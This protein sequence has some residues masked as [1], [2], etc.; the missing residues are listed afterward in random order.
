[1]RLAER[2]QWLG[3][4]TAFAV[5]AEAHELKA[6]GRTVY[7]FHLGDM[8]L[9]TPGTVVQGA[10][11]ALHRGKTGYCP[12]A[13]IP[14]LREAL[15]R[16]MNQSRG[17]RFS[18]ANVAVQPGGK[19]VISKFLLST[20]NP[21]D[22]VLYPNPG[23]PIYESQ[24]EFLGGKAVPYGFLS[25]DQGFQLD[26]EGMR[27]AVSP[28]TRLLVLNDMHN[29]TGAECSDQDLQAVAD[30]AIEHDLLVL[31]DEAYFDIRFEGQSR[32]LAS[33]PGMEERCLILYTFSK[34]FAMTGWRLGAAIGPEELIK[35][36]TRLNVNQESCSSHFLQFGA[37]AGLQGDQSEVRAI[38]DTLRQRRDRLV[39]GLNAIPGIAC[40]KPRSTFYLYPRIAPLLENLGTDPESFRRDLLQTTGVSVCGRHHFG[41]PGPDEDAGYLRL[42]YS[43]I[44]TNRIDEALEAL[45][46]YVRQRT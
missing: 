7:P 29:P 20:M 17:T 34:R 10:I 27:R 5:S 13:G 40:H 25:T 2:I 37:L 1:M 43:G 33:F 39:N 32:S 12:N 41:R 19:P 31:T 11:D 21:G 9:T 14:E 16:D 35:V 15:A 6:G 26:L 22:E 36:I 23:F 38:L 30:L 4:E 18:A 28:R 3:T 42:A 8:N 45:A 24:I 44:D 46:G